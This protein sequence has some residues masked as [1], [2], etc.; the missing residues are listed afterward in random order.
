MTIKKDY[1]EILGLSRDATAEEIKQAYRKLAFQYHPDHNPDPEA[2][3]KFKEI[4][5]AYEV[6]SDPEKRRK[7]DT[8]DN[9]G[10][11]VFSGF[12]DI[13]SIFESFFGGTT[14]RRGPQRGQDLA[15][16]IEISLEEAAQGVEKEI[17][18][19]RLEKCQQCQGSG[20]APGAN[21][22]TCPTCGGK[23]EVRRSQQTLFGRF[24]NITTCPKCQGKG[25]LITNPCPNCHGSGRERKLSRIEI[26]I[27]AGIEDGM[28]IRFSGSGD[29]GGNNASPG[30]LFVQVIIKPHHYFTRD[31]DDILYDLKVNFAQAA[32]GDEITVPTIQGK[33]EKI[34]I[35]AGTESGSIIKLKGKGMPRLDLNRRGDQMVKVTITTPKKL[36]R[37]ERELLEK[38][39]KI[40]QKPNA[41]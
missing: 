29:A 17:E 18:V 5:E 39:A 20:L 21:Y 2:E 26:S 11:D 30:D 25:K 3:A 22:E 35:P 10:E 37:E 28:R 41:G 36:S 16:E 7:Y 27:P 12:E 1:Y 14:T 9:A 32:L 34:K 15:Y 6:V 24:T 38:L 31:G 19:E 40:W 8:Y 33:P 4:N 13:G 23:G